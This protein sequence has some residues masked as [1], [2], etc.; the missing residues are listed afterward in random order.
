VVQSSFGSG[1]VSTYRLRESPSCT[2]HD[3]TAT[4]RTPIDRT[5]PCRCGATA[6]Y[7]LADGSKECI[8]CGRVEADRWQVAHD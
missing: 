8:N 7:A 5:D 3:M 1:P 2:E 4:N 6:Y